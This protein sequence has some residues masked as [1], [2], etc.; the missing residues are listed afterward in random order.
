M[1]KGELDVNGVAMKAG[2][3]LSVSDENV[4]EFKASKDEAEFL[5]FD[6]A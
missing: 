5:L 3:G 4:W 1:V 6:L 2:D